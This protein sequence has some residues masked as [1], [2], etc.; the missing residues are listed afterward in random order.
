MDE[1]L[2]IRIES[3]RILTN[4]SANTAETTAQI[5]KVDR[6]SKNG[7]TFSDRI[8]PECQSRSFRFYQGKITGI[9]VQVKSFETPDKLSWVLWAIPRLCFS[10]TTWPIIGAHR[11]LSFATSCKYSPF[12]IC[13]FGAHDTW[14]DFPTL[15][16]SEVRCE[17]EAELYSEFIGGGT[18][19]TSLLRAFW[20]GVKD[21]SKAQEDWKHKVHIKFVSR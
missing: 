15:S 13:F 4:S 8:L 14:K 9:S 11:N 18:V 21:Q 2:E 20:T 10:R 12:S 16:C 6:K 17:S 1:G 3:I 19:G 7:E 5:K